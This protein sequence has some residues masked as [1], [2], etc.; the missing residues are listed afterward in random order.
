MLQGKE[1][2][3]IIS[4]YLFY[5][6]FIFSLFLYI[7]WE[8]A[9]LF[10]LLSL[11]FSYGV[12][13]LNKKIEH[14]ELKAKANLSYRI[15]KAGVDLLNNI[16]IG[17]IVYNEEKK[18]EWTNNYLKTLFD[19]LNL[20]K[21]IDELFITLKDKEKV[22]FE[23]RL[24][25]K[26]I[27]VE[28]H[29]Q[30]RI[31]YFF[32]ITTVKYYKEK[33]ENQ[34]IVLGL[35]NY[36]NVEEVVQGMVELDRNLLLSKVT[37]TLTEWAQENNLFLRRISSDKF[38]F[39]TYTN[40]L[41]VLEEN[42]FNILD[43]VREITIGNK[44]P[45]TLSIGIGSGSESLIE[46]GNFA[47]SALDIAL[48]RGGD[49]AAI[50]QG[51]YL[52]FYGGKTNAVEKRT[53]VRA[54]VISH[55]IRDL[56]LQSDQVFIMGHVQPDIDAL[57]SAIG[58]LK[59]V[60][61]HKKTGYIIFTEVNPSIEMMI[62]YINKNL[63]ELLNKFLHPEKAAHMLTGRTLLVIVDTHRPSMVL[64]ERLLTKAQKIIVIDHHRRSEEFIHDPILVYIEPYASSTSELITE[65]LDY[66]GE[67]LNLSEIEAT[68]LLAGIVVDTKSFAYRTGS[69]T[70]EAASYLRKLG[71]DPIQVQQMLKE[72]LEKYLQRQEIIK[73]TKIYYDSIAI[74]KVPEVQVY[75]QVLIAKAADTLLN[76]AGVKASFVISKRADKLINISGRSLGEV[77]VQVILEKMGGGGHL[78]NAAVQLTNAT[79]EEANEQLLR[80]LQDIIG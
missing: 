30:E 41:K 27:Q 11:I 62:S 74:A 60:E 34:R 1:K 46:L 16:P 57:A 71:A 45:L 3:L 23:L 44:I 66:Q 2:K 4:I 31:I 54:R 67:K 68:L 19:N 51:E 8:Y 14:N 20:S 63:P 12:F 43:R 10:F 55:A 15:K 77:N 39:I 22:H 7:S 78:N 36:D 76:I 75:D 9:L 18:I 49:Q 40:R 47:Q 70:F 5:F 53:R 61:L 13:W 65:L 72:S 73:Y 35:I 59:M 24:K 38:I 21:K 17:I 6:L 56:I 80:I 33:T 79:V 28:H 64:E 58:V 25:D 32:D 50:K 52:S 42:R 26:V 69:R 29:P 48:G 37:S